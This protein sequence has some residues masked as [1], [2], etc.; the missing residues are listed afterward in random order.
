MTVFLCAHNLSCSY[1]AR[2]GLTLEG[3]AT[4]VEGEL[5]CTS[6]HVCGQGHDG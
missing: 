5:A 3:D 1:E 6:F 2:F 4:A